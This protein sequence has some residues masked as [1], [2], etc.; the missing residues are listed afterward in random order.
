MKQ[1]ERILTAKKF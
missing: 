1:M